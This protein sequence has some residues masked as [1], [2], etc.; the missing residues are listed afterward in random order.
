M[1]SSM[2]AGPASL[3]SSLRCS[4][5]LL[6]VLCLLPGPPKPRE[7]LRPPLTPG[8]EHWSVRLRC[9]PPFCFST[10]RLRLGTLIGSTRAWRLMLLVL[11]CAVRIVEDIALW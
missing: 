8:T 3:S 11:M 6:K 5:C 2:M 10:V 9:F 4:L 1:V 7:D